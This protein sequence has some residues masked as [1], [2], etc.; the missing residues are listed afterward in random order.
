MNGSL[1]F[2]GDD[3]NGLG[4]SPRPRCGITRDG[5]S[6]LTEPTSEKAERTTA[7][8]PPTAFI[9]PLSWIL[10]RDYAA[11]IYLCFFLHFAGIRELEGPPARAE[12]VP[13]DPY[14]L[15]VVEEAASTEGIAYSEEIKDVSYPRPTL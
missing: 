7:A 3:P 6:C 15:P 5:A 4:L 13:S 14:V 2:E 10:G 1:N 8:N 12:A 9:S 11:R